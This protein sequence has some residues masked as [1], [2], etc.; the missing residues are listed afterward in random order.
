MAVFAV[1]LSN[2][3]IYMF[4]PQLLAQLFRIHAEHRG[5]GLRNIN[6]T[7]RSALKLVPTNGVTKLYKSTWGIHRLGKNN[8]I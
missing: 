2:S 3:L 4:Q 6:H 7:L 1:Y 8:E 5:L